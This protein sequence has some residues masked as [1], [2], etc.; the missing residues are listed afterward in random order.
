MNRDAIRRGGTT[1]GTTLTV[2]SSL[3]EP[4][5]GASRDIVDG[6]KL[7]LAEAHGEIGKYTVNF[8]SLDDAG[9]GAP[10]AARGGAEAAAPRWPTRRRRP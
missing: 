5:R 8:S 10:D 9:A 2:Y 7:A 3:P 6:E 4:G 1:G